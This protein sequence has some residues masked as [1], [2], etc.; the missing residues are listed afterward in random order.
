MRKRRGNLQDQGHSK[1]T[2]Y[3][4]MLDFSLP[5]SF[6]LYQDLLYASYMY[7]MTL[8]VSLKQ[9]PES[10]LITRLWW[11]LRNHFLPSVI[12]SYLMMWVNY[13]YFSLWHVLNSTVTYL[14]H[15]RLNYWDENV[16][17]RTSCI[18]SESKISFLE[19]NHFRYFIVVI[20]SWLK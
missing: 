7:Q 6:R 3:R 4:A 1:G 9:F 16:Q 5:W 15:L 20:W 10:L 19:V 8:L 11:G 13:S 12:P 18:V 2:H 14:P 17:I